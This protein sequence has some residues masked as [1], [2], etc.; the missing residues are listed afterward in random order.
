MDPLYPSDELENTITNPV[1]NSDSVVHSHS[2][3]DALRDPPPD[4]TECDDNVATAEDELNSTAAPD[5]SIET[6]LPIAPGLPPMSMKPASVHR[7]SHA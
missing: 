2:S 1:A 3:S 6:V 7:S 4:S 5:A